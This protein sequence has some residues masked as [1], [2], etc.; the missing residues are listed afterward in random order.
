MANGAKQDF[1]SSSAPQGFVLGFITLFSNPIV[2]ANDI[3]AGKEIYNKSCVSC[4]GADAQGNDA[5][6][7][8]APTDQHKNF[9]VRQLANFTQGV[10]GADK[11]DSFGQQMAAMTL[12]VNLHDIKPITQTF[13]FSQINQAMKHLRSGN[14]RYRVVL[15]HE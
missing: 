12:V 3:Q 2:L 9:L 5:L 10:R 14:A 7:G 13:P 1:K 11:F 6:S 4:R 15:T 8:R